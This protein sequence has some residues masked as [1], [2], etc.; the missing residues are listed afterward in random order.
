MHNWETVRFSFSKLIAGFYWKALFDPQD[1]L[2]KLI[3]RFNQIAVQ[4][5]ASQV[6]QISLLLQRQHD[7]TYTAI[8]GISQAVVLLREETKENARHARRA[9]DLLEKMAAGEWRE[10]FADDRDTYSNT[11]FQRRNRGFEEMVKSS[12]QHRGRFHQFQRP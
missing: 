4:E 8:E 6:S 1:D 2:F 10:N 3:A 7:Q 11:N 12:S 5:I 9:S